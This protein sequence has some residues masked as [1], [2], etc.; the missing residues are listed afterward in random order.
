[1]NITGVAWL[2]IVSDDPATREFYARTLRLKLLDQADSYAYY[3]VDEHAR[4]EILG[5]S[6]ETARHQ[7]P[8]AP[9]IGFLVDD[10]DAAVDEL[11]DAGVSLL[12]DVKEWRG[13]SARHRW[14][15]FTDPAGNILLLLQR[16]GDPAT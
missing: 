9:A 10:L 13:E 16:Q 14:V 12:T 4:V 7:R 5:S 6:S 3:A 8:D 2:G 11:R 1:V 15:Y